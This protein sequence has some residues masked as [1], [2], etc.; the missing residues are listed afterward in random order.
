M[1]RAQ[2]GHP[3]R[4]GRSGRSRAAAQYQNGATYDSV[5]GELHLQV[6]VVVLWEPHMGQAAPEC[7]EPGI[8]FQ[9]LVTVFIH[10]FMKVTEGHRVSKVSFVRSTGR[11]T[12][13][14]LLIRYCQLWLE[15]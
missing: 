14:F 12:V 1:Q 13:I 11:L 15:S 3:H 6:T 8:G 9:Q 10:G 2:R 4:G 7:G 5:I